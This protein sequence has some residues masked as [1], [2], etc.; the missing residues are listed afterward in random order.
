LL[1]ET[2]NLGCFFQVGIMGKK[3]IGSWNKR[4][5]SCER[6]R[7]RGATYFESAR[8]L[9]HYPAP[10]VLCFSWSLID[11]ILTTVFCKMRMSALGPFIEGLSK[12]LGPPHRGHLLSALGPLIEGILATSI[13]K[14]PSAPCPLVRTLLSGPGWHPHSEDVKWHQCHP[15]GQFWPPLSSNAK[16]AM[17]PPPFCNCPHPGALPCTSHTKSGSGG[18]EGEKD[19]TIGQGEPAPTLVQSPCQGLLE[20]LHQRWV[21]NRAK[22]TYFSHPSFS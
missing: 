3:K 1:F 19:P 8:F 22:K 17:A 13:P 16:S 14:M 4:P 7:G 12:C 10:K 21:C 9:E 20:H 2:P 18:G 6:T 5:I 15:W 11:D